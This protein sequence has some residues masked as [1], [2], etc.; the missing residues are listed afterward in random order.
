LGDSVE[1]DSMQSAQAVQNFQPTARPEPHHIARKTGILF[2]LHQNEPALALS[3]KLLSRPRVFATQNRAP[4]TQL[5]GPVFAP[6]P[7]TSLVFAVAL[8]AILLTGSSRFS[9]ATFF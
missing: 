6:F 8:A 3:L 7:T 5:L 1:I 2:R 4:L 9:T